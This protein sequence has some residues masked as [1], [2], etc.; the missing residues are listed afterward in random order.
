MSSYL[1]QSSTLTAFG[2]A[3]RNLTDTSE[4]MTPSEMISAIENF[5]WSSGGG[6]AVSNND[7]VLWLLPLS[8]AS[9]YIVTSSHFEVGASEYPYFDYDMSSMSGAFSMTL[10]SGYAGNFLN[11]TDGYGVYYVPIKVNMQD[12]GVSSSAF[13]YYTF[14]NDDFDNYLKEV[15]FPVASYI[16]EHAFHGLVNLTSISIPAATT[17]GRGAF[18]NC[19]N[20]QDI[21]FPVATEIG[22][23]AFN[24]CELLSSAFLP[25]AM[26][27]YDSAFCS[28][29][30]LG[31]VT[32]NTACDIYE[33][34]F[35]DVVSGLVTS[36]LKI[37]MYGSSVGSCHES[38][39]SELLSTFR[40]QWPSKFSENIFPHVV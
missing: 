17:I 19:V 33:G 24:A 38:V 2:N 32:L 20:L 35:H 14:N 5:S 16:G 7:D 11:V 39:P 22:S 1:I 23:F 36:A 34:A 27:I 30:N 15:D 28:C 29:F 3:V 25:N 31:E 9:E 12:S 6:G 10:P 13:T 4:A 37:Y 21:S 40:S 18:Y 26:S 8:V